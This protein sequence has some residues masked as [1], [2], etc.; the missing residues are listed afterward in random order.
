MESIFEVVKIKQELKETEHPSAWY[1]SNSPHKVVEVARKEIADE[2]REIFFVVCLNNQMQVIAIHRAHVGDL[3]SAQVN[4]REV[5]KAAILN[6]AA[7]II[8][9]HQH[10]SGGPIS[11]ADK[12]VTKKLVE[13]GKILDIP[14]LDHIVLSLTGRYTSFKEEGLL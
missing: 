5:N 12:N 9:F 6:N 11:E 4:A 2:D 1:N 8:C 13:A 14:L 7:A 10:P 3:E